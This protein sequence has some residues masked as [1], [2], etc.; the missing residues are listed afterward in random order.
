MKSHT[1]VFLFSTLDMLRSMTLATR[2][3][4]V[5]ILYTLLSKKQMGT[6]IKSMEI[7][8]RRQLLLIE[9]KKY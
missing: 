8:I 4:I 1:K 9:E 3:P 7:N 5:Y 6:F 2:K